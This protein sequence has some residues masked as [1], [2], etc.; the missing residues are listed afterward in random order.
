MSIDNYMVDIP[1]CAYCHEKYIE[2]AI[3]G[4]VNQ[5]TN[6][7]YRLIIGDDCSKDGTRKIIEK[8]AALYPDKIQT[9]FH[10]K[11]VGAHENTR[12]LF[13]AC[14]AKY[15]ALCDGD[16]YWTDPYKLQKQIDILENNPEVSI[17]FHS[18]KVIYNDGS[19]VPEYTGAGQKQLSTFEDLA[20]A[21]FINT[22]SC[23]FR[24][25]LSLTMPSWFAE[26][27]AGDWT[28]FLLNA[29]FGKIYYIDEPMA[30]YRI[31][32]SSTWASQSLL[33]R[34]QKMIT[35]LDIFESKFDSSYRNFFRKSKSF[36]YM[37]ISSIYHKES[38]KIK[39]FIYFYKACKKPNVFNFNF[40]DAVHKLK[41]LVLN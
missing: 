37:E 38:N 8:Y 20:F 10:E 9:F 17:C 5:K 24:N 35:M 2:E 33:T 15:I 21:N 26:H 30:V 13:K 27:P 3:L 29:Q 41:E 1:M 7:K 12:I 28:L 36:Y 6:F 22:V 18:V 23:V 16:D 34:F 31:S 4:I 39:E 40:K 32:S 14:N 11:N 19:R 25:N